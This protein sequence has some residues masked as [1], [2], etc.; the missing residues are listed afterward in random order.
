MAIIISK[1]GKDSQKLEAR[2]FPNED[3]LQKYIIE[4][5]ESLPLS[6]IKENIRLLIISREFVTNSGPIDA[7]A[8]DQE[9]QLYIIET[10]LYKNPDKRKVIAQALDYGASLWKNYG[11]YEDFFEKLDNDTQTHFKMSFDQRLK[12]FFGIDEDALESIHANISSN[13]KEGSI[14]F[15]ILM[16][17][18]HRELKDLITFVNQNSKFDIY[19]VELEY[20]K[21]DEFEIM[22]PK[23]FGTEVKKTT[24][25]NYERVGPRTEEYH[26]DRFDEKARQLYEEIKKQALQIGEDVQIVPLKF[27]IAFKRNTNFMDVELRNS[28]LLVFLNM[29][30]GTL[31]DHEKMARDVRKIGHYGNGDYE[32]TINSTDQI[33]YVISLARKSYEKN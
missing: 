15:V 10:K 22:I 8:I 29:S 7:L 21:H 12:D 23:L 5:P 25:A 33:D 32:F 16:D 24:S 1:D 13:L 17:R 28:K 3:Y 14:K 4:N 30:F 9:G 26:F 18:L 31:D 19:A 27:Y 20:Y 2:D 6:D 11:N